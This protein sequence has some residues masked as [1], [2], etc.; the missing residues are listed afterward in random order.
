[1][2]GDCGGG[3]VC[4][5]DGASGGSEL[6]DGFTDRFAGAGFEVVVAAEF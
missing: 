5:G 1:L 4:D 3:V 2:L 6:L